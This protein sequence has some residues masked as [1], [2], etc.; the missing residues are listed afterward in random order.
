MLD[1]VFDLRSNQIAHLISDPIPE[2]ISGQTS[3]P[4]SGDQICCSA[5]VA[6]PTS[7]VF[8]DCT[9]RCDVKYQAACMEAVV[10][11]IER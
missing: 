11:S 10:T 6:T 1:L 4:I 9:I 2:L 3:D 5:S 7:T 8:E